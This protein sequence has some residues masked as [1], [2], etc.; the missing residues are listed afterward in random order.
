MILEKIKTAVDAGNRVH[1]VNSGYVV[2]R[3]GFGRYLTYLH[4][5]WVSYRFGQ[6]GW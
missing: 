2:K 1:W 6:P 3:D 4:A 5:E